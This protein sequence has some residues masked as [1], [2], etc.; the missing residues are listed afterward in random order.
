VYNVF[1][2]AFQVKST[3]ICF[4]TDFPCISNF[5]ARPR[6]LQRIVFNWGSTCRNVWENHCLNE[7]SECEPFSL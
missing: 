3:Q 4:D 6:V 7:T 1:H 2:H 5:W